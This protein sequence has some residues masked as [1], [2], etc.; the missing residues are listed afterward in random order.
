M[1]FS[2]SQN[3]HFFLQVHVLW[4]ENILHSYVFEYVSSSFFFYFEIIITKFLHFVP[5][6]PPIYYYLPSFKIIVFFIN[7]Y[8]MYICIFT[9]IDSQYNL[10]S[11]F[12]TCTYVFS[13]DNLI[14]GNGLVYSS[15]EKLSKLLQL[16][17]GQWVVHF[18]LVSP[19]CATSLV[20]ASPCPAS[21]SIFS[22]PLIFLLCFIFLCPILL[23]FFPITL[24]SLP[25]LH[26]SWSL[27][28]SLSL[29]VPFL[30]LIFNSNQLPDGSLAMVF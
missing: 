18:G 19:S 7:Y 8:Y 26:L 1:A 11:S 10:H 2:C 22:S 27:S 30:V 6:N 21:T 15:L 24:P 4:M 9:D 29:P 5:P 16:E 17:V 28:L 14:L 3:D 23:V 25:H 12:V 13:T 20:S